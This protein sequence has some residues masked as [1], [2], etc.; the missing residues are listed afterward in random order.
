ML[1]G[2][3]A[4]AP[5][6]NTA[7]SAIMET[8][9]VKGMM[10]EMAGRAEELAG[11]ARGDTGTR[12]S[13]KAKALYGNSQRLAANAACTARETVS[14]KP[15]TALSVAIGLGFLVGALWASNRE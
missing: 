3:M 7:R 15:M 5:K 4:A 9:R 10:H 8:T 6:I 14:G 13:G 2:T 11:E 1:A 12:L